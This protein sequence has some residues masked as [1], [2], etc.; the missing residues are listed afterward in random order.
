MDNVPFHA[1]LLFTLTLVH[2]LTLAQ[3][4]VQKVNKNPRGK[5]YF[6]TLKNSWF[7]IPLL[8]FN[9]TRAVFRHHQCDRAP[10]FIVTV[11]SVSE[12]LMLNVANETVWTSLARAV[13]GALG[14]DHCGYGLDGMLCA[15]VVS[16]RLTLPDI[17]RS[18]TRSK[19]WATAFAPHLIIPQHYSDRGLWNM[20]YPIRR[21]RLPLPLNTEEIIQ[22]NTYLKQ[23][24]R[25]NKHALRTHARLETWEWAAAAFFFGFVLIENR[26][27]PFRLVFT[28]Y[29]GNI[30]NYHC[31]PW[32]LKRYLP[33]NLRHGT[34]SLAPEFPLQLC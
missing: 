14:T 29:L 31:P 20:R 15:F 18:Q 17:I 28:W 4:P 12:S 1:T 21:S 3:S 27:Y 22:A 24:W 10:L 19:P 34:L 9:L 25:S 2:L 6:L 23:G 26:F 7:W 13:P 11:L 16:W 30:F 5:S 33:L 8:T 32:L